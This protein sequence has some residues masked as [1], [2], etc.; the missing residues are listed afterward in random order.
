MRPWSSRKQSAQLPEWRFCADR[1]DAGD[2]SLKQEVTRVQKTLGLNGSEA[3]HSV[4]EVC[5]NDV[6]SMWQGGDQD[7]N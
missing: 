1:L 5:A 6:L 3:R 4:L 7:D 2:V